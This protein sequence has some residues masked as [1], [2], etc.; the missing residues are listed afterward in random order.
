MIIRKLQALGAFGLRGIIEKKS[1]FLQSIPPAMDNLEWVTSNFQPQVFMPELW[2]VLEALPVC[3]GVR[4][5]AH[6][7]ERNYGLL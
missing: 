2:R 5:I 4:A 6:E 1:S 3:T 7:V